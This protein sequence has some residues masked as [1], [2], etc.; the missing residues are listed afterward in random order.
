MGKELTLQSLKDME[1]FKVFA[2]GIVENSPDGVFMTTSSIGKKLM[3]VAKRGEIH[4]WAI[5]IHWAE[6]GENYARDYGDKVVA[7]EYIKKLVPC[8]ESAFNM[9]RY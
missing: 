3:W 9:Y 8:D 4:D 2:T 7:K 6:N 1:P 5:Y